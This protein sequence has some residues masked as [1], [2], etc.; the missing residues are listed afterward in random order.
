LHADGEIQYEKTRD[1]EYRIL[2]SYLSVLMYGD[3]KT[4]G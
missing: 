4:A 1:I 3:P 2:P